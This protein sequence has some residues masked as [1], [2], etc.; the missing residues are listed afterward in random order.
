MPRGTASACRREAAGPSA[1]V[2]VAAVLALSATARVSG[3]MLG[4]S[5][6]TSLVTSRAQRNPATT[7][8]PAP[9]RGDDP[10]DDETEQE[11]RDPDREGDRPEARAWDVGGVVSGV[12]QDGP[13]ADSTMWG[14]RV[15]REVADAVLRPAPRYPLPD[16][17]THDDLLGP[18]TRVLLGQ[19]V[20]RVDAELAA[21]ELPARERGRG[22]RAALP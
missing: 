11:T 13:E 12:A 2:A 19:L 17:L 7:A 6:R 15:R 8:M 16:F 14:R 5:P 4:T 18:R 22:G 3:S 20:G 21:V 1:T 9:T 10:A